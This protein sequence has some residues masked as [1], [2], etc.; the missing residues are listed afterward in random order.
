VQQSGGHRED[1]RVNVPLALAERILPAIKVDRLRE[2][3]LRIERRGGGADV[4][5]DPREIL[6][7]LR[8]TPDGEFVTMKSDRETVRVAK[9]GGFV[10]VEVREGRRHRENV[11][12]RIP[13]A[14]VEALLS[15][16]ENELNL[17]AAVKALAKHGDL[18][19]VTVSSDKETVR[20]WVDSKNT[21]D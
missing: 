12:V 15:G 21:A 17:A 8:S 18:T 3:R 19:L 7:A 9:Q 5:V 20:I 2:G 16:G 1:V 4:S 13:F 11:D 6:E 14:V 10:V